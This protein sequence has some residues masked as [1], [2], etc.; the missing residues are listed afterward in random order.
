MAGDDEN[1]PGS[2]KQQV[3][4]L[5][6]ESLEAIAPA[7]PAPPE[8]DVAAFVVPLVLACS[9]SKNCDYQCNNA[10]LIC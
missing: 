3:S 6:K 10:L 2:V 9:P 7:I 1:Y 5:F 4:K 8:S